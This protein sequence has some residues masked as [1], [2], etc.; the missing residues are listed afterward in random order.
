[1]LQST[2]DRFPNG[3][4]NGSGVLGHYLMDHTNAAGALGAYSGLADKY[5]K[6]RRPSGMY[7]PRFR[8]LRAGEGRSFTRGYAFEVYTGRSGWQQKKDGPGLGADL[9]ASMARPGDWY[10]YME[11]Y[12]ETLPRHENTV[13]L[14]SEKRDRWGLPLLKIDMTYGGNERAMLKDVKQTATEML[15]A[16]GCESVNGFE[17]EPI[18]GEVI[19]EMGTARMGRD[20]KTSFLNAFN[21]CH[22]SPNV[23]VTDGSC[24]PSTACQN[25]S[26]T[27]MALTAR[28]CHYAVEEMRRGAL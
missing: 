25:P 19:H 18:P 10:A 4:A 26:F 3:F 20:P 27:Y 6:G 11:G 7:I 2:S 9:K 28:A 12:C 5:Y 15:K 1:L 17:K 13:T 16:A 23:F 22:E 14:S 8:N 24:M 21:Q